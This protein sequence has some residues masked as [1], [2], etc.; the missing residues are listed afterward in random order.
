MAKQI[1]LIES[2]C[3]PDR[4]AVF[5]LREESI[6]EDQSLTYLALYPSESSLIKICY[7][8]GF[9]SVYRFVVLPDHEDFRD[10]PRRKRQRIML[11]ASRVRL[12]FPYL[13]RV[14]EPRDFSDPWETPIGKILRPLGRLKRWAMS[15]L[16]IR[17]LARG[18]TAEVGPDV[19]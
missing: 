12:D 17:R 16:A 10:R 2:Y 13:L 15:I 18:G 5:C 11:L 4:R 6:L 1:L 8:I 14:P 3:T 19:R 9:Q 7:K